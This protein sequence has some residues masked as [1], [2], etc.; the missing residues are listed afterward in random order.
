MGMIIWLSSG[1][2]PYKHCMDMREKDARDRYTDE[3]RSQNFF[4]FF[5]IPVPSHTSTSLPCYC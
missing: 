4:Q 5:S 2:N 1:P 3:T